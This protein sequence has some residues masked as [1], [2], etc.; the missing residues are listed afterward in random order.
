M[1]LSAGTLASLSSAVANGSG[2]GDLAELTKFLD[3]SMVK[4]FE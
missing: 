2:S 4:N 3:D 1:P